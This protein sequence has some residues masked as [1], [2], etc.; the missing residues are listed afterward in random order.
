VANRPILCERRKSSSAALNTTHILDSRKMA[1]TTS[2]TVEAIGGYTVKRR[3]PLE[4]LGVYLELEHQRTGARH[5]HIESR[6]DN[7]GLPSSFRPPRRIPQ[8][9]RTSS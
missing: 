5:I 2:E 9:S 8:E 7:N 3:E 1:Q 4:R 6:D